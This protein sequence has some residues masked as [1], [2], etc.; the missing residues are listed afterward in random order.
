MATPANS[1]RRS[2]FAQFVVLWIGGA[3]VVVMPIGLF[4]HSFYE[5][6][7]QHRINQT[8]IPMEATIDSSE[9][10]TSYGSKG[11]VYYTPDISYRYTVNGQ[12]YSSEKVSAIYVSRTQDYAQSLVDK[13]KPHQ[14]YRA[15]RDPNDPS[16][17]VLIK[18]YY[19]SPYRYM[20][21]M[22]VVVAGGCMMTLQVRAYLPRAPVRAQNGWFQLRPVFGPADRLK[23][24]AIST[25]MWYTCGAITA[26]HYF[27]VYPHPNTASARTYFIGFAAI[28]IIGIAF[29]I[30]YLI[31][32]KALNEPR[33]FIEKPEATLSEALHFTITQSAP[34][35]REIKTLNVHVRCVRT[36]GQGKYKSRG[37]VYEGTALELKNQKLLLGQK[38]DLKGELAFPPDQAI[39]GRDET[40]KNTRY[41]WE[42]TFHCKITHAPA[43]DATFPIVV[44]KN[45][46]TVDR[47][48]A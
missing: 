14:T 48:T 39:T 35:E 5:A 45:E 36:V 41:D 28:G 2:D 22:A 23:T 43:Y 31:L 4:V 9:L 13:F 3:L 29:F 46:R 38:L 32:N 27:S 17:S 1:K 18:V 7:R 8:Y 20:L 24:A 6:I 11:R 47:V 44:G 26:F 15:Y 21:L 34:Q 33:I 19:F 40:Q 12:N 37:K 10:R 16:Q 25:T 30:R 42:L